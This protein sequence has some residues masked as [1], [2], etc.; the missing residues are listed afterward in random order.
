M[1]RSYPAWPLFS[2][3]LCLLGVAL[4]SAPAVAQR[5][6]PPQTRPQFGIGYV[7]NAPDA[8]AG[9]AA[10]VILP[11]A[12]GIGLYVDAKF[13]V[14]KPTSQRGYD[15]TATSLQVASMPG[16]TYRSTEGGWQSF[17]VA[18]IRPLTAQFWIYAGAG[19]AQL[20]RYDLYDVNIA[21][22][23]G[24]GGVAW[25]ENPATSETRTNVLAGIMTRL[26]SHLTAQFGYESQPKGVTVGVTLRFPPW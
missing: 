23:V 12:G 20:T 10:Y 8:M 19:V 13:D 26:S 15:A 16:S 1:R 6:I 3:A 25:V 17:N 4:T 24:F 14:N 21:S 11:G 2:Y 5:V 9:G 18:V 7:A 22:N